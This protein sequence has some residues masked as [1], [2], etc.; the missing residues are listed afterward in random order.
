MLYYYINIIL[1]CKFNL[2]YCKTRNHYQMYLI[3]VHVLNAIRDFLCCSFL[4]YILLFLGVRPW[5]FLYILFKFI[6]CHIPRSFLTADI[7]YFC[8]FLSYFPASS[9]YLSFIFCASAHAPCRVITYY[10]DRKILRT[11]FLPGQ[12]YSRGMPMP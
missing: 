4:S 6:L 9:A 11:P 12:C 10:A 1:S 8:L 7:L 5:Y 3:N 2:K